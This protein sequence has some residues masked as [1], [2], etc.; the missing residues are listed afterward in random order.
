MTKL[1]KLITSVLVLAALSSCGFVNKLQD[2]DAEL[3]AEYAFASKPNAFF[4]AQL[5]DAPVVLDGQ[6][7]H[8]KLQYEFQE[9][10]KAYAAS[11]RDPLF[12]MRELWP[13]VDGRQLVRNEV[14]KNWTKYTHTVSQAVTTT[15]LS[16]PGRNGDIRARLYRPANAPEGLLPG[17][18]YMHGG[19]FMMASI[20][21]VEPQSKIIATESDIVVVS[22]DYALAPENKFPKAHHDAI[23]AFDWLVENATSLGIDPERLGVGG[24]S[25]GG[26]LAIVVSD[27]RA[28]ANKSMPKAQLLYYPFT[29]AEHHR[30]DSYELFA[31]GFGLSKPFIELATIEIV[32][33]L[34]D[35]EHRWLTPLRK[36]DFKTQPKTIVATAGFDPI[37]DQGII[38][39]EQLEKNGIEVQYFHYPSLNHGFLETSGVIDDSQDAC[40]TTARLIGDMLRD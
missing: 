27:E 32:E 6:T 15:E 18:M 38:F 4:E 35:L 24:D 10:R 34:K 8:P 28:R 2:E 1:I 5:E 19:A 30:Y 40:F 17:L 12:W 25:A 16:I 7:L 33:D 29:D 39:A 26:N 13:T 11:D 22:I 3:A 14:D 23:D 9:A 37:R 20:E 36:L 21:A 31:D